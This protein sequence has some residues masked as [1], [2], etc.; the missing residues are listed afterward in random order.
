M[1]S[2]KNKQLHYSLGLPGTH[3][4]IKPPRALQ[5]RAL[6]LLVE[7]QNELSEGKVTVGRGNSSRLRQ[8]VLELDLLYLYLAARISGPGDHDGLR[9]LC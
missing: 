2:Y 9:D 8:G 5:P 3:P 7:G 1:S 4:V 6:M